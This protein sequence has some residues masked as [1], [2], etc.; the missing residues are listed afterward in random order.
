[1]NLGLPKPRQQ[2][3]HTNEG[4][5]S[6]PCSICI[7]GYMV[8]TAGACLFGFGLG[9]FVTWDVIS[10]IPKDQQRERGWSEVEDD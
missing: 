4:R 7:Y 9:A 5:Q 8:I 1:M 3:E 10:R 6:M 2:L